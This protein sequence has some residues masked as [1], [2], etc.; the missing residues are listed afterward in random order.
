MNKRSSCQEKG[1]TRTSGARSAIGT[2]MA[3]EIGAYVLSSVV[4]LVVH[5]CLSVQNINQ[6]I[7]TGYVRLGPILLGPGST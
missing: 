5:K 2:A 4:D 1:C 7:D 6:S 3:A